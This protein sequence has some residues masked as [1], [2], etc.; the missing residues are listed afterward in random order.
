MARALF[1]TVEELFRF[2][3]LTADI[4]SAKLVK[5]ILVAQDTKIY[6]YLGTRLFNKI[7]DGI[8]NENLAGLYTTLLNDYIK[9]M[10][11]HWSM[12]E[13]LPWSAYSITNK[14]VFKPTGENAT[15]VEKNEFDFLIEK[16]ASIAQ[17]YTQKFID[18]MAF[19]YSQFPEY[20]LATDEEKLPET[21]NINWSGWNI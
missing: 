14:G 15:S 5:S 17:A 1:I 12:V 6:E 3:N 4:D 19:N 8:V 9:P 10:V 13:I 2:T 18:Y 11:I 21:K 16:Q 7:N 20:N